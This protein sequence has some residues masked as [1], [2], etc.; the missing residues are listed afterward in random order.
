[1]AVELSHPEGLLRQTD[2]APLAIGTGSR[3]LFLAGQTATSP[4]GIVE[5]DDLAGQVYAA[6]RYVVIGIQGGGG[7]A[8]DIARLTCYIPDW[9]LDKWD[10]VLD[11]VGRAQECEGVA[12]PMPPITIIGVQALFNPQLLVEIEAIAIV[13]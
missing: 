10:A 2:Y 12:K 7:E 3:L 8:K 9:R 6:L 11:G 5:A 13:G 4:E 1:M